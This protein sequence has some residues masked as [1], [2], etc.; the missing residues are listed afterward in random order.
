MWQFGLRVGEVLRIKETDILTTKQIRI[1]GE[2]G[3]EDRFV[4]PLYF[5]DVWFSRKSRMPVFLR[6]ISRFYLYRICKRYGFY[7]EVLGKGNNKVTHY[8]RYLY[9]AKLKLNNL[10]EKERAKAVGHKNVKSQNYYYDKNL[11]SI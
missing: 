10:T 1:R 3:S 6:N 5:A 2:K 7:Y 4:T 9:F 11:K 8:F